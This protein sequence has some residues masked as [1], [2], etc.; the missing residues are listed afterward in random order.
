MQL[1]K[2]INL[3][4]TI[5]SIFGLGYMFLSSVTAQELDCSSL[6]IVCSTDFQEQKKKLETQATTAYIVTDAPLH[7]LQDTQI[8]WLNRLQRCKSISCY[9]QQLD[10]RIDQLNFF[11]SLNQSLTQHYLKVENGYL[12]TK[13]PIHIQVHQL[14]KNNIKIE[15][16]A[17]LN[18]NNKPEKQTYS[19]LAYSTPEEK[20]EIINN[21]NDCKYAVK[22]TKAYIIMKSVRKGCES[23]NGIYRLYD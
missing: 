11:S 16:T 13:N 23:F 15:G 8:I 9:R 1:K 12:V 3:I 7:L 5:C 4:K 6:K 2:E 22:Y 20:V 18:P 21:N 17:Y 19:L 14:S 10:S